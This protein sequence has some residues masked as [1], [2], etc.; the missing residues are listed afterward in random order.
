MT[1]ETQA[2]EIGR[3]PA[4]LGASEAEHRD[5][6]NLLK[7]HSLEAEL[8]RLQ[9]A[10]RDIS[11]LDLT[12][13]PVLRYICPPGNSPTPWMLQQ[14]KVLAAPFQIARAALQPKEPG[15]AE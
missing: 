1:T 5:T 12:M 10:L 6:E 4:E 3:L 8:K 11:D 9:T 15:D 14:A 13:E 2:S 7:I